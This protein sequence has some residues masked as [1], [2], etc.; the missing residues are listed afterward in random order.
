MS[1]KHGLYVIYDRIA[2]ESG[3]VFSAKNDGVAIRSAVNLLIKAG[4]PSEY[5][6]VKV[7]LYSPETM[8]CEPC[9]EV[10]DFFPSL[11]TALDKQKKSLRDLEVE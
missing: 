10:L 2:Q 3:P 6:L 4:E 9:N 8:V 5:D 11:F 7:A 1:E